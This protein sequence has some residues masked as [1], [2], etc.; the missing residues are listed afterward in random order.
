MTETLSNRLW[1]RKLGIAALSLFAIL[2]MTDPVAAQSGT[3]TSGGAAE[4]I[5][6][7]FGWLR[8]IVTGIGAAAS[9]VMLGF[10]LTMISVSSGGSGERWKKATISFL[11]T[12]LL[13]SWNQT[14]QSLIQGASKATETEAMA[15]PSGALTSVQPPADALLSAVQLSADAVSLAAQ[16]VPL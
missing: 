4:G 10:Q 12:V 11:I 7:M 13:L 6:S 9:T 8:E 2:L 1:N 5:T 16:A 14:A 15:P 3:T